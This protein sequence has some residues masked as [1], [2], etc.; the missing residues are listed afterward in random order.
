M[1]VGHIRSLGALT[2]RC[3]ATV[4]VSS[5]DTLTRRIRAKRQRDRGLPLNQCGTYA[6][7]TLDGDPYCAA[8]AGQRALKH[9]ER[10]TTND[11]Q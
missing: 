6:T 3:V 4:K 1:K 9:L 7:H 10:R 8:H 11:Q 2:P 5:T